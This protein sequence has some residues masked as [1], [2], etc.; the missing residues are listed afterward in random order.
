MIGLPTQDKHIRERLADLLNYL[1]HIELFPQQLPGDVD[2][3]RESMR[4]KRQITELRCQL[5]GVR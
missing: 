1:A 5:A 4:V 3:A 2:R